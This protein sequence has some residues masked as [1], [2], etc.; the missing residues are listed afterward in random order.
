MI[1]YNTV[2]EPVEVSEA[3]LDAM[4][5]LKARNPMISVISVYMVISHY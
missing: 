5:S 2:K 3:Q 4:R 1:F